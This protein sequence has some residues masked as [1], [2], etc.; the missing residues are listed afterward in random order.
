MVQSFQVC[1]IPLI[2]E[3]GECYSQRKNVESMCKV[4]DVTKSAKLP[5]SVDTIV[6][7]LG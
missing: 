1:K 5:F 4:R 2:L 3:R 7:K 6:Q